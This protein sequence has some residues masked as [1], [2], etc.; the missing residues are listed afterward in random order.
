MPILKKIDDKIKFINDNKDNYDVR[1]LCKILNIHHSVY[2]YHCN[3][4]KNSYH[5]A[6]QQL[7]CKIKEIYEKSKGRYGSPKITEVLKNQ[8]VKASQKRVA[9]RM[10]ELWLRSIVIKKFNH[11]NNNT[12]NNTRDGVSIDI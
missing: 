8:G 6:N 10:K 3:N 7:D 11:S 5:K 4:I 2:Y 9:R 1:T 12:R